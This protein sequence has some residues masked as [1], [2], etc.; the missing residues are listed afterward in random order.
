MYSAPAE[1]QQQLY[2]GEDDGHDGRVANVGAPDAAS[3]AMYSAPDE[4]EQE[5]YAGDSGGGGYS[6]R[7]P[8]ANGAAMYSTPDEGQQELYAGQGESRE[9]ESREGGGGGGGGGSNGRF[10]DCHALPP[11]AASLALA[12]SDV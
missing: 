10:P 7:P 9:G 6:R 12:Q 11:P 4:S 2:D 8:G 5:L 3:A 1:E